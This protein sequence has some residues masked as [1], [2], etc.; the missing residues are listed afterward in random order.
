[1]N[2]YNQLLSERQNAQLSILNPTTL[3]PYPFTVDGILDC[4]QGAVIMHGSDGII[5]AVNGVAKSRALE[6]GWEKDMIPIWLDD[7]NIP[8]AKIS[9]GEVLNRGNKLCK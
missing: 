8:S 3:Q 4:V 9:I 6:N 5:Y 7:P 2:N 1:M